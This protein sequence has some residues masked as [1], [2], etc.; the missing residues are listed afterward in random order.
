MLQFTAILYFT[1]SYISEAIPGGQILWLLSL[2]LM[3]LIALKQYKWH[4]TLKKKDCGLLVYVVLL[5]FYCILSRF[6]AQRPSLITSK[7]NALTFILAAMLVIELAYGKEDGF[8]M[9]LKAVMYG[10]YAVVIFS[11]LRYGINGIMGLLSSNER[12]AS[13]SLN[14]NGIGMCAAF[15]ILI[16]VHFILHD[17]FHVR[18]V[19]M[20]PAAVILIVSQSRKAI[21][22]VA[23]GLFGIYVLKNLNKK[24][25][26][27][28]VVKILGVILAFVLMF[29][30]LSKVPALAKIFDRIFDI[31][32]MLAGEGVRG[33]N[34]AWIRFAYN[35]LGI[36]LFKKHPVLG[37]GINNAS[38]YTQM[39][40]GHNH[41]LHNNYIE[42]LACGGLVGFS[43]YYS[44]YAYFL[45]CFWKYRKYRDK[46]FDICLVLLLLNLVVDYG[47]VSY[48]GKDTYVFAYI[49]WM[50]VNQLKARHKVMH[51]QAAVQ[52]QQ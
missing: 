12:L 39:V 1:L 28:T 41:Y 46:E 8:G 9:F 10:G 27:L 3:L 33:Q 22:I 44:I 49:Y 4:L 30:V 18:D 32:E 16:N 51:L 23:L 21:L 31:F 48:Y 19:L 17:R 15:S 34:S 50:K 42:L 13:D 40:Y 47:G 5:I 26:G 45:Y 29:I 2:M 20:V 24:N 43:L 7:I 14:A 36:E 52:L 6:W 11:F 37:I 38:I 25:F 35:D